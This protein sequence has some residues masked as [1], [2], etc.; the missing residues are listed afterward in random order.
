MANHTKH[1]GAKT[2]SD[3][4]EYSVPAWR[5]ADFRITV[6]KTARKLARQKG[7]PALQNP[8]VILRGNTVLLVWPADEAL[9]AA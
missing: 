5:Y 9:F 1:M 8:D 7:Y 6:L 2:A 3:V 4:F